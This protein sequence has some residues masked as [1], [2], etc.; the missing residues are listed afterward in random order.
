MEVAV[1]SVADTLAMADGRGRFAPYGKIDLTR[2]L[3]LG[4]YVLIAEANF[5]V[6]HGW[7]IMS[8]LHKSDLMKPLT[9]HQKPAIH[10]GVQA[11]LDG[12]RLEKLPP[13]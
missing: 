2:L 12:V 9:A 8:A 10:A 13:G 7:M 11:F 4:D 6:R 5:P 1:L 3:D